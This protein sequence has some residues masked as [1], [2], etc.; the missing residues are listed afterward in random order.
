MFLS[1]VVC[2]A[3][4]LVLVWM[5]RRTQLS[6]G[7]PIA[8]LFT[9]LLLHVPGAI[10]HLLDENKVLQSPE[11]TERGIG[12]TAIGTFCFVAGVWLSRYWEVKVPVLTQTAARPVFWQF[13]LLA[14]WFFTCLGFL[15]DITT[16]GAA[17][18]RGG[19]IWMLGVMLGLRSAV[20]AG[21]KVMI[22]RWLA[23]L[24]V[25]PLLILLLGGFLSYG[26]TA[27]VIVLAAL[28]ITARSRWRLVAF[29]VVTVVFGTSVFLTY[30]LHRTEIRATIW[31]GAD[32]QSRVDVSLAA[33]RDFQWFDRGNPEHLKAFDQR[34][35]QN[36]FAGLA[37]K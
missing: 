13:C 24:A 9:L 3:G 18:D 7:I 20:T 1:V 6:L 22:F 36:Y 11:L 5:L 29:T 37:A 16:I 26:S 17:I 35:N 8:Y 15:T 27:A 23:A 4:L 10:A 19:A 31:G 14:G 34:L 33:A 2:I 25:Y 28:V 32:M 12:F 21:N 30:F